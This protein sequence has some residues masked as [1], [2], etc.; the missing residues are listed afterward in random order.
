MRR[1][2]QTGAFGEGGRE[3][4]SEGGGG[5]GAGGG[6]GPQAG[7]LGRGGGEAAGGRGGG[8]PPER[9]SSRR[10]LGGRPD[11]APMLVL[12]PRGLSRLC[13]LAPAASWTTNGFA[14]MMRSVGTLFETD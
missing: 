7:A 1:C 10:G 8:G 4:A 5:G 2:K 12:G 11:T 6:R 3:G 14:G 9:G 13:S